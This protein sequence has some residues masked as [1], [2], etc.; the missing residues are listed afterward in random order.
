M[1]QALVDD[2]EN[3][4]ED[5]EKSLKGLAELSQHKQLLEPAPVDGYRAA[6]DRRWKALG[7][8]VQ[9]LYTVGCNSSHR[10]LSP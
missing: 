7:K 5:V 4:R 1:F 2:V 3:S 6:L 8:E 9:C 10:T